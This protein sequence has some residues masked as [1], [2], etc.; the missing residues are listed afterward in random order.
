LNCI[1]LKDLKNFFEKILPFRK[2]E[3]REYRP[4]DE[5]NDEQDV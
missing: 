1:G 2:N 5:L 4:H 3:R